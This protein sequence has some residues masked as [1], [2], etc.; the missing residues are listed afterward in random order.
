MTF[1]FNALGLSHKWIWEQ[2]SPGD[3]VIDATA[4]RGRDTLFLSKLVGENGSVLSF[5]IQPEAI[6]STK[7]LLQE[8]EIHNTKVILS[9]HSHIDE[10][11]NPNS[12][13]A[14]MFNFG[15]LPGGDHNKFSHGDTSILAINKG[16]SL[17]KPGGVMTLC[18]YYGKETGYEERDALL[19]FLK[20][21]D[22]N[23]YSVLLHDFINR[24]NEPPL[25][26]V[27]QK[28]KEK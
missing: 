16:L 15:W 2:V 26:V 18:I 24:K 22:Q 12:A 27:I 11:A 25:C 4:G 19:S 28:E 14:I 20:T 9:C 3:L 21:L 8:N 23:H 13:S 1:S 6:E 7:K 5:D 17:L 10:F